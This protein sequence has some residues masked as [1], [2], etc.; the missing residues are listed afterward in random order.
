MERRAILQSFVTFLS[1]DFQQVGHWGS[2]H[3]HYAALALALP[4]AK[5]TDLTS[6]STG[7]SKGIS[8]TYSL[9]A[10]RSWRRC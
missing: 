6:I 3:R 5:A 4:P 8:L 1:S 9:P 2:H 10:H 7:F